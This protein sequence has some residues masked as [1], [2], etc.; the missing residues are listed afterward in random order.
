[1]SSILSR[2]LVYYHLGKQVFSDKNGG[3]NAGGF[4]GC[5]QKSGVFGHKKWD[6]LHF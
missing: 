1:M 4:A 6:S 5:S 2:K 3:R